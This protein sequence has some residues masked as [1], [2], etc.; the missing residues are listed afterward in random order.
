MTA[1]MDPA[2]KTVDPGYPAI[3]RALHWLIAGC[4]VLQFILGE[5][6]EDAAELRDLPGQLAALAYHK[7][8]GMTVLGLAVLRVLWR[9]LQPPKFALA[10]VP[11]MDQASRRLQR[12]APFAH[13][14]LYGLLFLLPLSGWL[15]SSASAYSVSWFNLFQFPDLIRPDDSAKA[16]L[17]RVHHFAGKALFVVAVIHI[18]A[19]LKH[20][21]FDKDQVMGRM[22]NALGWLIF[23]ATVSGG[24]ALT[25]PK[26]STNAHGTAKGV[27]EAARNNPAVATSLPAWQM[28][29]TASSISFSAVQAGAKFTGYWRSFSANIHFSP[30]D[31]ANSHAEVRI[32]A[33][34]VDTQDSDRDATLAGGDWFDSDNYAAVVF[35]TDAIVKTSTGFNAQ[36]RLAI[37]G[38]D[39][40]VSFDFNVQENATSRELTGTSRLDRLA[41]NLGTLEWLDTQWVGQYVDVSVAVKATVP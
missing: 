13:Y 25:L 23:V 29:P 34:R 28:D 7:S 19:A 8:I 20:Q 27:A 26:P 1:S 22:S 11:A 3:S 31:L 41:L 12:L 37:R 40:P 30:D 16:W 17:Q 9:L 4:I 5:R 39:Y 36:G 6:A 24:I 35:K 18:A 33:T 21:F 38:K 15:M 2:N 14:A 10:P 32:D